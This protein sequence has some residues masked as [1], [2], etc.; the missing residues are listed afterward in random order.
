[1]PDA[2]SNFDRSFFG[3]VERP[4]CPKCQIRMSLARISPGSNGCDLVT[5]ECSKC[6]HVHKETISTDPMKSSN[7]GWTNSSLRAPQ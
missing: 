4:S 6:E 7:A 3:A 5:F 1:M 2:F